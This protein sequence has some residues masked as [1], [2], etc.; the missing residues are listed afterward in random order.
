MKKIIHHIR[1][2]PDHVKSRYVIV[3]AVVATIIV[4]GVWMLTMRMI[5]QNDDTIKTES[6]FKMVT[7]IFSN[8]I[9]ETKENY[10]KQKTLVPV[11]D[12]SD[13]VVDSPITDTQSTSDQV[14]N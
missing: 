11:K 7:S 13:S 2:Q 8:V 5:E 14:Q 10:Q 3:F 4:V 12:I 6:P 1:K 9:S